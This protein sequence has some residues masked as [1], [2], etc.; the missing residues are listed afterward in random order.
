MESQPAANNRENPSGQ[1]D[2]VAFRLEN[3]MYALP[4]EP[5]VRIIEMVTITPIP[6]V[7]HVVEGVINV[8]GKVVPVINMRRHFG[9]SEVPLQL[10]TPIILA[11]DGEQTFGLIVDEVIDVLNLPADQITRIADILPEEM[12]KAPVLRGL[13]HVQDDTVLLLNLEHLLAANC[14]QELVQA[15][16]TLPEVEEG[17]EDE[18]GAPVKVPPETL[19]EKVSPEVES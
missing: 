11:Q 16:A 2:L 5:I 6:E 8:R 18:E 7:S 12:G 3:Q 19:L 13:A 14:M 17:L 9:L 15:V 1:Q 4:I 10:R